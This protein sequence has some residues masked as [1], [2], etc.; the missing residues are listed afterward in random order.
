[1]GESL[2]PKLIVLSDMDL[3]DDPMLDTLDEDPE[4]DWEDSDIQMSYESK[5][6]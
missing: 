3:E 1:M 2:R 5:D 4:Q 6:D